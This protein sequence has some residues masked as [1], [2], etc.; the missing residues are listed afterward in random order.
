LMVGIVLAVGAS[1]LLRGVLY[2]LSTVDVGS[3]AGVSLLFLVIAV[4]A[5]YPPSRRAMR[6]DPVVALRYEGD[7]AAR[8]A[9]SFR[10]GPPLTTLRPA[11]P[12]V[13]APAARRADRAR[14]PSA[15]WRSARSDASGVPLHRGTRR[16]SRTFAAPIG[17]RT[18]RVSSVPVWRDPVL[19]AGIRGA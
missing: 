4:L 11:R 2:G 1:Y 17:A 18:R 7:G 12:G 8:A 14:A 16:R 9:P 6:V 3:F 19:V 5:A 13:R 10:S 15:L